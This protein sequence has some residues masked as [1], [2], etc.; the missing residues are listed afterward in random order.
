MEKGVSLEENHK[1]T[2][3]QINPN[4]FCQE[5]YCSNCGI[6]QQSPKM[7][8]LNLLKLAQK[9]DSK[10]KEIEMILYSGKAKGMTREVIT[11]AWLKLTREIEPLEAVGFGKN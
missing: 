2:W 11:K 4:I 9:R 3:C 6:Y 1:G 5:G 7:T 10:Q 8:G